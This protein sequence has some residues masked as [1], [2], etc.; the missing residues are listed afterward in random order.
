MFFLDR[1]KSDGKIIYKLVIQIVSYLLNYQTGQIIKTWAEMLPQ[2]IKHQHSRIIS[3]GELF[4]PILSV[5]Q[6]RSK[7]TQSGKYYYKCY[8]CCLL[9]NS[10]FFLSHCLTI[11][12]GL[13]SFESRNMD[14]TGN[15][16]DHRKSLQKILCLVHF[17]IYNCTMTP[18][19]V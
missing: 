11:L 19:A 17:L 3:R 7:A 13:P 14:F 15:P 5:T 6:S 4:E 9:S 18:S 2:G 12:Q 16:S 8:V 10:P 1:R